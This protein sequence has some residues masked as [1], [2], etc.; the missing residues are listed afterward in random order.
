[1]CCMSG[2]QL[3]IVFYLHVNEI[4]QKYLHF[5][6]FLHVKC[7]EIYCIHNTDRVPTG[8]LICIIMMSQ[9]LNAAKI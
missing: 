3:P 8:L 7:V 6:Y 2:D 9:M 1:M 5:T 4:E